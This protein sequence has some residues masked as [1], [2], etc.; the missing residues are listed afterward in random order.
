VGRPGYL[1]CQLGHWC[2]LSLGDSASLEGFFQQKDSGACPPLGTRSQVE[3][4]LQ[5]RPKGHLEAP[6]MELCGL[7][8]N[9]KRKNL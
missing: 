2:P 7:T 8:M 9:D 3:C 5:G 4:P 1:R 6:C